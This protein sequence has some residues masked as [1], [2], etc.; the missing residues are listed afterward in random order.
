VLPLSI[1][2]PLLDPDEGLHAS[3]AQ[4]MVERGD[5][6]TPRLAGRPFLDKPVCYVWAQAGSLWLFGPGEAAVRLPGLLF[7]LLGAL[8]TGLLGGRMF[9]RTTG[10]I[11][12]I[13]YAT[14]ILPTAL[15]Q[16]AS[17]DVAL[18]P[19]VNLTLL[20]FW[21]SERAVTRRSITGCVLGAGVF[22]GLAILTKGL[23]GAM[24]VGVAYGGYLLIARRVNLA[25]VLRGAC[26]L[27]IAA[28]VASPWYV[29]VETR[30]PSYL[31]Y[32]FVERHVLGFATGSQPHGSEPW[33]YY[34]PILLGGGLPWIGYLPIVVQDG[35]AR[36]RGSG[37]MPL[38]WSWLIGWTLLVTLAG[39]KLAT[40]LW[41]AFPPIAVLSATAWAGLI[42]R[43]LGPAALRS[44]AR[45]FVLSSSSGPIVLP[46]AVLVV[47]A[48]YG[49]RF[50]WPVWMVVGIVA[51]MAPMPLIWWRAGRPLASL[52]AAALS[53]AAQFLVAMTMVLPPVAETFSARDLAEHFNHIGKLPP[54]LLVA[55]QRIGSLVFY[56]SPQLRAG[57]RPDQLQHFCV[58]EPPRLRPGDVVA[59]PER[60]LSRSLESLDL[61][62]RPYQ[63]VGHYRLYACCFQRSSQ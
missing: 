18:V 15:A 39:S 2:F 23:V 57:L 22:L 9:D 16:A 27:L 63:S 13:L 45:T 26:V 8:S 17:H 1:S 12:G 7:G 25:I 36:G 14:M 51:A 52:T 30:N 3:I 49:V 34:L 61:A 50:A 60:W 48:V 41:P 47:Q 55:E 56:L 28:L 5:W 43:K 40:Y 35:W 58:D 21:E 44:F 32:F 53:V 4:E 31:Y 62:G 37:A 29:F 24:V 6:I 42:E 38:L 46:A 10:L 59:V 20:M 11:A 33:W 54:R 19:W